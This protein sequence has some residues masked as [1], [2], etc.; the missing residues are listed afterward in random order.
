MTISRS[1][2]P[3]ISLGER[4]RDH[5]AVRRAD[6]GVDALDADLVERGDDRVG[7]VVRA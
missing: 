5:A 1:S 2:N 4:E 3:R 7:L 6:D